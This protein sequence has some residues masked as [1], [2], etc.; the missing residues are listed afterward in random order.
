MD[1]FLSPLERAEA[2]EDSVDV[3]DIGLE[4]ED[5]VEV[6]AA[7]K[8]GVGAHKVAKVEVALPRL[9]RVRLDAPVSIVAAEP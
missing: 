8:I 2:L 5:V 1:W 3:T 9:Q 4:R 7:G 6:D